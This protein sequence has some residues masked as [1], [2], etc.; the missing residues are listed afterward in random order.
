MLILKSSRN[1]KKYM[2]IIGKQKIHFGGNP[3]HP[4]YQYRDSTGLGLYSH[5]NHN[6]KNK[7]R[8]YLKRHHGVNTKREALKEELRNNN[9]RITAKYL[10]T[11]YLW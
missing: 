2:A 7:R 4:Y 8:L 9:G 11:K 10:S 1:D 3:N 5:L 6:D